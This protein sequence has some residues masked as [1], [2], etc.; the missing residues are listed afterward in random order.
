MLP[1]LTRKAQL[2]SKAVVV[3]SGKQFWAVTRTPEQEEEGLSWAEEFHPERKLVAEPAGGETRGQVKQAAPTGEPERCAGGEKARA[4]VLAHRVGKYP[5]SDLYLYP[6]E[7]AHVALI[8][9]N[10]G[11][12]MIGLENG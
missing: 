4:G 6:G 11:F 1:G 9:G 12:S 3:R 5:F 10:L 7:T 8:T 2:P